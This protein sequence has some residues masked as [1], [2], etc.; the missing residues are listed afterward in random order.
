M[1]AEKEVGTD[2][3]GEGAFA[4]LP[5]WLFSKLQYN[6]RGVS[7]TWLFPMVSGRL[8]FT[9]SLCYFYFVWFYQGACQLVLQQHRLWEPPTHTTLLLRPCGRLPASLSA[10]FRGLSPPLRGQLGTGRTTKGAE[11]PSSK[12]CEGG[13]WPGSIGQ[14][15]KEPENNGS[16]LEHERLPLSLSTHSP[17]ELY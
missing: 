16:S 6:L 8:A 14:E 10:D 12:G 11:N 7:G 9:L 3:G 2:A 5:A 17:D 13:R 4:S 1:E 15:H